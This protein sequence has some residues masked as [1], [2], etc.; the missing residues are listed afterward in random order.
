MEPDGTPPC[1][2]WCHSAAMLPSGGAEAERDAGARLVI[3]G[4][5]RYPQSIFLNDMHLLSL[6]GTRGTPGDGDACPSA[7][8]RVKTFG[9]PPVPR[10][11]SSMIVLDGGLLLLFGGACHAVKPSTGHDHC[12]SSVGA[13]A[14]ARAHDDDDSD[15]WQHEAEDEDEDDDENEDGV[16]Y[17]DRVVDLADVQLFDL[18]TQTWLRCESSYAPLRGGVNAMFRCDAFFFAMVYPPF[19]A[20]MRAIRCDSVGGMVYVSG[21]MHSDPGARM[22]VWTGEL[23]QFA[24]V[25]P[26]V[27]EWQRHRSPS[28]VV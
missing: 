27:E 28:C 5:W 20:E 14:N 25:L 17:G 16:A 6:G 7:W 11:Q 2:R 22:P 4:G 8:T 18:K 13:S 24:A 19:R 12:T 1:P 3:F 9:I 21:G 10:C 15:G 23:A 26:A